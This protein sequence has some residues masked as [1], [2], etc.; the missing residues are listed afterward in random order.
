M[1]FR[2]LLLLAVGATASGFA[3]TA[4]AARPDIDASAAIAPAQ[5]GGVLN[6]VFDI[7]NF[8]VN[9]AGQLVANGTFTGTAVV[10]GVVTTLTDAVASAVVTTTQVTGSC[11]ILDL[12]LGPLHL[13]LLG[14]VVDLSEV[15]LDI[16]AVPGPGNL[17]GNLLCA[18]AGLLDGSSGLAGLIDRLLDRIND[19][20]G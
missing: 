6:G 13:D 12:D 18:V 15:H 10:N 5:S 7:T 17:L 14:L 3:V 9:A 2:L 4:S 1:K 11:K 20:L 16:T 19:I 8:T